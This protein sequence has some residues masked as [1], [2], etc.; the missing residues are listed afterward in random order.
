MARFL[1]GDELGGLKAVDFSRSDGK[2]T[3][4]SIRP[5][6][7]DKKRAIQRLAARPS[8]SSSSESVLVRVL[9]YMDL[10]LLLRLAR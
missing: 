3:V 6:G 2:I 8:S 1:A 7:E 10:I 4:T 9:L 5:G